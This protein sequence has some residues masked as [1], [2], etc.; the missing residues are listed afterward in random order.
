MFRFGR[1]VL[2]SWILVYA[3][4]SSVLFFKSAC[5]LQL[6]QVVSRCGSTWHNGM[7]Q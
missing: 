6:M 7:N 5:L 4:G 2:P 1:F 3:F